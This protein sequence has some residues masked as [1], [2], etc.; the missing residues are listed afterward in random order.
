MA[1]SF[2]VTGK[3]SLVDGATDNTTYAAGDPQTI[4]IAEISLDM[5]V[6]R[7]QT[8]VEDEGGTLT[9]GDTY[10]SFSALRISFKAKKCSLGAFLAQLMGTAGTPAAGFTPITMAA[11]AAK[12]RVGACKLQLFHPIIGVSTPAIRTPATGVLLYQGLA[13][14]AAITSGAESEGEFSFTMDVPD[15]QVLEIND[16]LLTA[17]TDLA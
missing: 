8:K 12:N 14:D 16:D 9:A 2:K 7:T 3:I 4:S 15:A 6:E 5:Q 17:L 10:I 11:A 13:P 1:K